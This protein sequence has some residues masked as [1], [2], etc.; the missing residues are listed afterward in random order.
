[1]DLNSL[2]QLENGTSP[3][4]LLGYKTT[5]EFVCLFVDGAPCQWDK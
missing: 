3:D 2:C 1:M 4:F 5:K